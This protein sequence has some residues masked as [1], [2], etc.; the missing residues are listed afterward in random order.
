MWRS[1]IPTYGH[2]AHTMGRMVFSD[3]IDRLEMDG[4]EIGEIGGQVP[5]DL[6]HARGD[7]HRMR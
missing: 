2:R 3:S 4:S 7:Y 6:H 5:H 1:E